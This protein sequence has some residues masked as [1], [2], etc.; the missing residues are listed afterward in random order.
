MNRTYLF[1]INFNVTDSN[2]NSLV[3]FETSFMEQ[4]LHSSRNDTSLFVVV[5]QT[6]H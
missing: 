6:K 2:S 5:S 1:I 4:L 3:E